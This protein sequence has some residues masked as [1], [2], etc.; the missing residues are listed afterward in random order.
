MESHMNVRK[1]A[2]FAAVWALSLV[3]VAAWAQSSQSPAATPR[4]IETG[5]PFGEIITAEN[6]GF[7]RIAN[8]HDRPGQVT[9]RFVVKID[10][11]WREAV[12]AARMVKT[13]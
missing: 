2:V 7:Q 4:T 3:G 5:K 6:I 10:G 1:K 9:G 11:E 12:D 13:R 8:P